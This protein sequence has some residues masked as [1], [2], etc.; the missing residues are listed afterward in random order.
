M[1]IDTTARELTARKR[2]EDA[3]ARRTSLE[4]RWNSEKELVDQILA[5]RDKLRQKT[6]SV[7][8]PPA[9]QT[10][11]DAERAKLLTELTALQ[12]KLAAM[13]GESPLILPSVDEQAVASVVGDWTGISRW[14][15]GP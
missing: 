15:H 3:H 5:L 12:S 9:D 11:N 6:G 2:L 13:Q 1:G 14:T 10:A 7:E 8:A 4:E